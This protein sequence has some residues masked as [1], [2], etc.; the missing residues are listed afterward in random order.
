MKR[1]LIV[2]VFLLTLPLKG[3]AAWYHSFE[4]DYTTAVMMEALYLTEFGN[5]Q[6]NLSSIEE[7]LKHYESAEIA[8]VGIFASKFLDRQAMKDAGLLGTEQNYYYHHI[9]Y[10]VAQR[11][12]P[13]LIY[14]G[15]NL[16]YQH[17]EKAL[18][19]GPALMKICTDVKNLCKEF[20][21][22]V[23]NGKLSFS[24]INFLEICPQLKTYFDLA[25]LSSVDWKQLFNDLSDFPTTYTKENLLAD[26]RQMFSGVTM[27]GSDIIENNAA[28]VFDGLSKKPESVKDI[29]TDF[30]NVYTSITDG[31]AVKAFLGGVVGDFKDSLAV[32]KLFTSSEYNL[33]DFISSYLNNLGGSYY[34]Q[35]W[36]IYTN[37]YGMRQEVYED[38]FDS[39]LMDENA[40]S[41]QM[42]ILRKD[43]ERNDAVNEAYPGLT[44][45]RYYIGKDSKRSYTVE[46][47][48]TVRGASTASIHLKCDD[49]LELAKGS[50]SFKVN[51]SYNS[52]KLHDYAL[53]PGSVESPVKPDD[54]AITDKISEYQGKIDVIDGQIS[55]LNTQISDLKAQIDTCTNASVLRTLN[56]DLL[57]L[58]Y[59]LADLQRDR[60]TLANEMQPYVDAKNELDADYS[61]E[62]DG[63]YRINSVMIELE[64]IVGVVW[65]DTGHWEGDT[66][67]R[68]GHV[69]SGGEKVQFRADVRKTRGEKHFLFIRIRRAMV[70]V[71]WKLVSDLSSSSVVDVLT[72]DDSLSDVE[73]A[74]LV[75]QRMEEVRAEN[76]G[77]QV[78]VSYGYKTPPEQDSSEEAYHLLWVGDRVAIAREIDQRLMTINSRLALLEKWLYEQ[79]ISGQSLWEIFNVG[80]VHRRYNATASDRA[81]MRWIN[82]AQSAGVSI[83]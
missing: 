12:I 69:T 68:N 41:A 20:E 27:A 23:T 25:K 14:I 11:I 26:F 1:L 77:C 8:T 32:T 43:Y 39:R 16:I 60:S 10:L 56:S 34:T 65:D 17:P 51:P 24:D 71:D 63:P 58:Q 35:R 31:T 81:F 21:L 5:E 3:S 45:V 72:I 79:S 42:E 28:S 70:Q 66:Y 38:V 6:L 37:S 61:D 44:P 47:E 30:S 54:T 57:L 2:M 64:R 19:W 9:H 22:V 7:M 75:N 4:Y 55:D 53:P 52:S 36:Y 50:F 82:V 40:F 62:L 80:F 18:Y 78:T 49:T 15:Q 59:D 67:V 33:T 73:A 46:N 76:P 29:L 13:R 83:H 48:A 74:N